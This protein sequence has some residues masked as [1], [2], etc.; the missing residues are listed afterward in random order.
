M[1][2]RCITW[3]Q[4]NGNTVKINVARP[5]PTIP[6]RF[7]SFYFSFDGCKKVLFLMD[8]DP[9]LEWMSVI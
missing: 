9:L 1:E 4:S 3:D 5:L 8:V 7:G 2:V 6:P